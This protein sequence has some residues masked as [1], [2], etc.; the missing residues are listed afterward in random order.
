MRRR[1]SGADICFRYARAYVAHRL[2]VHGSDSAHDT[3]SGRRRQLGQPDVEVV[4]G[5]KVLL[6]HSAGRP[7]HRPNPQSL[8]RD[9]PLTQSDDTNCHGPC[10]SAVFYR[11]W[12]CYCCP[13]FATRTTP[14]CR[15]RPTTP[16]TETR[17]PSR[18]VSAAPAAPPEG[19]IQ[20][21]GGLRPRNQP[22]P[23]EEPPGPRPAKPRPHA[24]TLYGTNVTTRGV[25][26]PELEHPSRHHLLRRRRNRARDV[27]EA[28]GR[29]VR[30]GHTPQPLA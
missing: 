22:P 16:P 21:L 15:V 17:A 3:I 28:Q 9:P 18:D 13:R 25:R 8:A 4:E 5:G 11:K 24:A 20:P 7:A 26:A 14:A 19:G 6:S 1:E 2:S 27:D 29:G 30:T 12:N 23:L 10:D